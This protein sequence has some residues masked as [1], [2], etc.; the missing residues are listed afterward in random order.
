M[1]ILPACFFDLEKKLPGQLCAELQSVFNVCAPVDNKAHFCSVWCRAVCVWRFCEQGREFGREGTAAGGRERLEMHL[2]SAVALLC[3][4]RQE[5]RPSIRA[6]GMCAA[7]G[8]AMRL[9]THTS[10]LRAFGWQPLP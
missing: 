3:A 2:P 10:A 4:V 8:T 6:D 1:P 5:V 9:Q 7:G